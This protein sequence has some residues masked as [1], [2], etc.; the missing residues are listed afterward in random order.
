MPGGATGWGGR[1]GVPGGGWQIERIS[2]GVCVR[3]DRR[4]GRK[5]IWKRIIKRWRI[6]VCVCVHP[7]SVWVAEFRLIIVKHQDKNCSS[8]F[9]RKNKAIFFHFCRDRY[10]EAI[11]NAH[12]L[13]VN[14]DA[15]HIERSPVFPGGWRGVGLWP[16]D[17]CAFLG[18]VRINFFEN[19]SSF[20]RRFWK[21]VLT[22]QEWYTCQ[23]WKM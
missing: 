20:F 10:N 8:S 2:W 9:Y 13:S 19:I 7:I 18:N 6:F 15:T 12:T 16:E 23:L 3:K 5:K 21:A 1:G 17:G 11:P 22:T 4:I 14:T